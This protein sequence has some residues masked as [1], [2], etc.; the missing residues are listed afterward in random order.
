MKN[1]GE[2]GVM[3]ER[4]REKETGDIIIL[5]MGRGRGREKGR[6]AWCVPLTA[7]VN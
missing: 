6:R 5:E 2:S 7:T 1:E 4:E 3:V